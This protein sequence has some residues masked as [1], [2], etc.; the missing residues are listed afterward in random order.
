MR[1]R[2]YLLL[3]GGLSL[4]LTG[5]TES[6]RNEPEDSEESD[7]NDVEVT[8]D[9]DVATVEVEYEGQWSGSVGNAGSVRTV[10]GT[11]PETIDVPIEDD[12]N[13]QQLL[14]MDD[15]QN[16]RTIRASLE[17]ADDG[18]G[19][20]TVRISIDGDVVSEGSTTE[21][22]DR[23]DLTVTVMRSGEAPAEG[24]DESDEPDAQE[25][26]D[27]PSDT[28]TDEPDESDAQE[29][30]DEV[31][32]EP[33]GDTGASPEG[34]DADEPDGGTDSPPESDEDET[35][36]DA[37]SG[38]SD[39]SDEPTEPT[40]PTESDPDEG[41]DDDETEDTDG[42][43]PSPDSDADSPSEPGENDSESEGTG[44]GL[45]LDTTHR[46]SHTRRPPMTSSTYTT[47][48]K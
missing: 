30:Q 15:S 43:D 38:E 35:D 7:S 17:K 29:E 48:A 27:E 32:D 2:R 19:V 47:D 24:T 31:D 3:T 41:E 10:D 46:M 40:E 8:S 5:C 34:D 25:E 42:S 23:V 26:Q 6:A 14:Q 21:R 13:G 37:G 16:G 12:E 44:D 39:G 45:S 18:P 11:G 9:A 1:R 4:S 22:S 33:D 28:T 36:D 20:L